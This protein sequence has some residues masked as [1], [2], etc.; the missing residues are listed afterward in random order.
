MY[1]AI[2]PG[3][4]L[5]ACAVFGPCGLYQVSSHPPESLRQFNGITRVICEK[6]RIYPH[7]SPGDPND[8]LDLSEVVGIAREAFDAQGTP[9]QTV[10]PREWKGQ[11][12]KPP[13]HRRVW[14]AMKDQDRE[15]LARAVN[16]TPAEVWAK[17]E[18]ACQTLARTGK[19]RGY[20]WDGHNL[21]DA[22]GLG[23]WAIN[24]GI[25]RDQGV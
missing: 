17:I 20:S 10:A 25:F 18:R 15:V 12:K 4:N 8:L 16:L 9:F 1:L 22:A 19:V 21:L 13:H 3:V 5:C 7:A 24:N 11:K 14:L 2:D 23:I 6:P